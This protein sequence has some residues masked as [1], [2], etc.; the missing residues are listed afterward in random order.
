MSNQTYNRCSKV[1][2][3]LPLLIL[4]SFGRSSA[5]MMQQTPVT[6][7]VNYAIGGYYQALPPD[8]EANSGKKYPLLI[9]IHGIGELGDGSQQEL[10]QLL[11]HGIPKVIDRNKFPAHFTVNNETFSFIVISPQYKRNYRDPES[12]KSLIDYCVRKYRVDESRIYLTGLSMGGGI[13]WVYA[14]QQ[15]YSNRIAALLTVCGNT[16]ASAA[17]I[18]N[19][20]ATNLP[21]WATHNQ[22]DNIVPSSNS[23][24]W[25]TGLNAYL[26]AITPR[27]ILNIFPVSGHDA[28]SK[29]YS[30]DYKPDGVNVY[31]WM[32]SYKRNN[33]TLPGN[34]PPLVSAGSDI[35]LTLPANLTTLSGTASDADGSIATYSWSKLT[36]PSGASIG[37]PASATTPIAGLVEG[38]YTFRLTVQDNKGATSY[39]DVNVTVNGAL[40]KLP[41]AHAGADLSVTLPV[42]GVTLNGSGTDPDG[43]I[44]LYRWAKVSGP[45][46]GTIVSPNTAITSF[47]ALTAGTY[48][49]KLTVTDN[50]GASASDDV[51]IIVNPAPVNLFVNAG[52]DTVIYKNQTRPDTAFL[53]GN[54]AAGAFLWS[55]ISGPGNVAIAAPNLKRTQVTGLTEGVHRFV[56]T[57]NDIISDTVQIEVKDWQKKN[58]TPCRPGGGKS[59]VL[60]ANSLI[61]SPYINRD[62]VVREKVMGGDTLFIKGG[63]YTGIELGD[64]GGAPGC[65]VSIMAKDAPVIIKD[66]FFRIG[67]RDSNVVQHTIID[68]TTLRSKNIP[69]AFIMD[70]S[71]R[72]LGAIGHANLVAG[73]VSNFVLKGYRSFNTGILQIKLDAKEKPFGR[74]DKFMQKRIVITDNFI[75]HATTEGLYIGHTGSNGG[76]AGNP[77]GPP[78]R[79]DSVEI[80]NNIV[81]NCGWD[82]IQLANSRSGNVIK[83]NFVYRTGL[84]N[85]PAQRAGIIMGANS[86]GAIDSNIIINAQG[87]GF[88][89]FGY[90]LVS[91]RGNIVDSVLA[92]DEITDGTYQSFV[93]TVPEVN[94]PMSVHNIGNL[95][96]RVRRSYI[97]IADNTNRMLPGRTADNIFIHPTETNSDRLIVDNANGVKENN[98]I[99]NSFPFK[100]VNI[101]LAARGAILTMQQGETAKSFDNTGEAVKWLF[102]RLHNPEIPN[103]APIANAGS[104]KHIT[105]PKDSIHLNGLATDED[106]TVVRTVWQKVSG[107]V[108]G[109]L[110]DSLASV[111]IAR[112]LV[113]GI[114]RFSFKVTDNDGAIHSDT[115][116]V[117]VLPAIAAPNAA[118]LVN[119]GPDLEITLPVDS[120]RLS[121]TATDTDGFISSYK[122]RKVAGPLQYSFDQISSS[123]TGISGLVAGVYQFELTA[124]D[125]V[126]VAVS[127]TVRVLVNACLP[128]PNTPPTAHAGDD[129]VITLPANSLVLA[130]SGT[131][132]DGHIVD[133][134]WTKIAGPSSITFVNSAQPGTTVKDLVAGVY[135]LALTVFDEIGSSGTDTMT[136]FVQ[137]EPVNKAPIVNAG[138]DITLTLPLDS[139]S[140][141][142][143]ASDADGRVESFVWSQISGSGGHAN[144]IAN[145]AV[146]QVSSLRVGNHQYVLTV[147]DNMG[148]VAR[149]TVMVRVNAPAKPMV[150][151]NAGLDRIIPFP[152]DSVN[153]HAATENPLSLKLAYQWTTLSGPGGYSFTKSNSDRTGLTSLKEGKY[154]LK[155][156]AIDKFGITYS[157]TL[158]VR[159]N[160]TQEPRLSVFPN[161]AIS[162]VN[163]RI[164]ANTKNAQTFIVI[165]N[166]VGKVMHVEEFTRTQSEMIRTVNVAQ[167]PPGIY[168]IE[169][170]VDINR[171]QAVKFLKN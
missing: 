35:T 13:S 69:Y 102:S 21:V 90:G 168:I 26:P 70:N 22:F 103:V 48:I 28:W 71:H 123:H 106:G 72:A 97:R 127:D 161:P 80:T 41:E 50:A 170:A 31:E 93:S 136:L 46:G 125:N 147:I 129:A 155:C 47:S 59:F 98:V 30:P 2:R 78:P 110:A 45:A 91:F 89:S 56:L 52:N 107:P 169:A 149:D 85:E 12:V 11:L 17:G 74:Y 18:A 58:V 33:A 164:E 126:G 120:I 159:V 109:N 40:N 158:E 134:A 138:D 27:S 67:W 65:P 82:G 84:A 130:G 108:Q 99:V 122:W 128:L 77:Y 92:N 39:D 115:V 29:T 7:S 1:L 113:A 51:K 24:N 162:T 104:D 154:V 94:T 114:Y 63:T 81:M 6:D 163:V 20:A 156:E 8:Y 66:G 139:L 131:D 34:Q 132:N 68:G 111:A 153:L 151:I 144:L 118:P 143:T 42:P 38:A 54:A 116:A 15:G 117:T 55:R 166:E 60:T 49:L 76:Q 75:N 5:Q 9:F 23:V 25:I 167:L 96:S 3:I 32:L 112:E 61:Y 119:A 135:K 140:L 124:T 53:N 171:K 19:I 165:Y 4:L 36:G 64:F 121:G 160:Y 83:N 152:Y 79:M 142:G 100:F 62:N 87:T 44:Q 73:W 148:A 157:D 145:K 37:S 10:P 43:T 95:I 137:P 101:S 150:K 57:L 105:L 133:Y 146:G 88:Q 14:K 141:I 86:S 16:D